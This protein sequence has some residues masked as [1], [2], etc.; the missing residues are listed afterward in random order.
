MH[1]V[2]PEIHVFRPLQLPASLRLVGSFV[3]LHRLKKVGGSLIGQR[4]TGYTS[5][6]YRE[7]MFGIPD[8]PWL[9]GAI[10]HISE[11]TFDFV[12]RHGWRSARHCSHTSRVLRDA[13]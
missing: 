2:E 5:A 1:V 10:L 4:R 8:Q 6:C 9:L 3:A 13:T 7:L 11:D 12:V